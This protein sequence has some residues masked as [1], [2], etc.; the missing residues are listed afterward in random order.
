M[1]TEIKSEKTYYIITSPCGVVSEKLNA[2]ELDY[3]LREGYF[4][5]FLLLGDTGH[6]YQTRKF[7][8]DKVYKYTEQVVETSEELD[9]ET[10]K[11]E[12]E[13]HLRF[14]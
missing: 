3:Y 9:F 1:E 10:A 7:K 11:G 2:Y 8:V 13:K 6:I 14:E 4:T 12:L 5:V